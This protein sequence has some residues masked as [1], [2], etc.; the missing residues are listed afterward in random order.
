MTATAACF[1]LRPVAKAFGTSESMIATRGFGRSAIAHSRSTMS[2]SSGASSRLDDLRARSAQRELV[3]GEVLEERKPD[4][5]HDHRD[6]ADAQDVEEDDCKDD[7]EEPEQRAREEH[8]E[9][10][11]GVTT[12]RPDVSSRI[13]LLG[14]AVDET[15]RSRGGRGW[16]VPVARVQ[17][18]TPDP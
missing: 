8:P 1:G 5:D 2:C 9:G 16:G 11:T 15:N 18:P 14:G 10:Q 4:D 6:Q 17:E 12:V 3:G 7:V 13:A